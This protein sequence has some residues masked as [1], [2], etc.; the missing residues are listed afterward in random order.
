MPASSIVRAGLFAAAALAVSS[1]GP[2]SAKPDTVT[3]QLVDMA[4]YML[5]KANDGNVHRGRG[6]TCG[7]ACA[8]EGFGVGLRAPDGTVYRVVGGLAANK[9]AKL[10]PHVGDMVTITGEVGTTNGVATIAANDLQIAK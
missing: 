8:R 9:N 4:C 7:Q 2:L 5:D 3:G 1:V 10:V 6:Y